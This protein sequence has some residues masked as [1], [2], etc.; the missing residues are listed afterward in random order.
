M[1]TETNSDTMTVGIVLF[2]DVEVLDF[3]GPF[4]VFAVAGN[5]TEGGFTVVTV[6]ERADTNAPIIARNGLK[7]VPD[8]ALADAPH[9]DLLV[10]P[11]GQGTRREVANPKLIGWIKRRATEAQLTTSVCTGA[12][13]LAETGILAGKT[14]T[15][16]WASVERMA[17]TYTMV[18]VRG[19][20]RF[21]DEGDIVT[22]AGVSAGIDMALYVVG[23]LK[24]AGIAA[25]TA[26]HMEDDNY[27]PDATEER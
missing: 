4:E 15:T 27:K 8:Y 18:H 13:L 24:G 26:R 25:K 3:A 22:S 1:A 21:V 19:D 12:F 11:G 17:Q 5:I 7:I 23:R 10:V 16:H 9:L 6:A 2:D 14:V 20:A